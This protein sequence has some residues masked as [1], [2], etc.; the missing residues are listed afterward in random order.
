M[1][2][3]GER[4]AEATRFFRHPDP[5]FWSFNTFLDA[6]LEEIFVYDALSLIFRPKYGQGLGRGLLGSDLD[7][8]RLVSGPTMRPLLDMHG[9]KPQPSG[10]GLPAVPCTGC[11]G[12]ITRRSSPG[13]DIDDYG[14]TGAEVNEFRADVMLYA[15]LVAR[16]ETPT[17]S[18]PWNGLCCRSSPG[19]RSRNTSSTS[20][21]KAPFLRAT[22]RLATRT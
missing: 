10:A 8:L 15:P 2:D 22:S 7:S 11:P 18:R 13:S 19:C 6:L 21:K 9:G 20:F 14:L 16:R 4:A 3:F 12:A 1:R 5:D 17:G